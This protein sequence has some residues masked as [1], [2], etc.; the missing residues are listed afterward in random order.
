MTGFKPL[1]SGET[2]A[3]FRQHLAYQYEQ[4]SVGK[5]KTG[6]VTGLAVTAT[7]PSASGSVVVG[8]GEGVCQPTT[9]GGAFPLVEPSDETF[10]VFTLNPMQFVANPRNDIIVFDQVTGLIAAL[11]GVAGAIPVD[12]T[13]PTT[14]IP[15]ARLRHAANAIT[16]PSN[17]IDDLREYVSLA[18]PKTVLTTECRTLLAAWSKAI[19]ANTVANVQWATPTTNTLGLTQTDAATFTVPVGKGGLFL[20]TA[21]LNVGASA[22]ERRFLE[23]FTTGAVMNYRGAFYGDG[24]GHVTAQVRMA[25]GDG[26]RV[27]AYTLTASTASAGQWTITRLGS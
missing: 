3:Q 21:T 5:A 14:A 2:E 16:I 23:I 4:V 27:Q 9:A 1:I 19:P 12:P 25:D 6:V 24:F 18:P 7:T 22:A 20:I 26:M 13:I 11:T 10:D 17:K 8:A 15:L